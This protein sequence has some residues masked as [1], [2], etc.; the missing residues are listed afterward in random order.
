MRGGGCRTAAAGDST[1]GN[2]SGNQG[3]NKVVVTTIE[4]LDIDHNSSTASLM[5]MDHHRGSDH[6]LRGS[7]G[8]LRSSASTSTGLT[9]AVKNNPDLVPFIQQQQSKPL[10]IS[11]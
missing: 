8:C 6:S 1:T 5:V 10:F 7:A 9:V 2:G 11:F 4:E 3:G